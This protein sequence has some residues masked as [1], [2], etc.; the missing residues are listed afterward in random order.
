MKNKVFIRAEAG[1][2]IGLGHVMRCMALAE[3]LKDKFEIIVILN[4]KTESLID[5]VKNYS[6]SILTIPDLKVTEEPEELK[7]HI[8][9]GDILVID[10]YSFKSDYQKQL[11]EKTDCKLVTIDD[12]HDFHHYA[13]VIINHAVG[14]IESKYVKEN[15]SKLYCG[16]EFALIRNEFR[17]I[18]K[19]KYVQENG[20]V[21]VAMGGSDP[22]NYSGKILEKLSG[23]NEVSKINLL[24]GKLNPHRAE[25]EKQVIAVEKSGKSVKLLNHSSAE[26]LIKNYL[27]SQFCIL[28][29]SGMAIEALASGVFP[30]V[31]QTADNQKDFFEYLIKTEMAANGSALLTGADASDEFSR[32]KEKKSGTR[33]IGKNNQ[34]HIEKIFSELNKL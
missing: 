22:L 34:E 8:K 32:L 17:N 16:L 21:L 31:I 12:L 13:D 18:D 28:S 20:V 5:I 14:G 4:Q 7:K 27:S 24:I 33:F 23:I 15:Y 2:D 26:D 19:E 1:T 9:H 29:S 6:D 10:G 30:W 3:V 11:K 25:L